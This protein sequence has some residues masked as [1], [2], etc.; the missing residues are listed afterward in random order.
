[1]CEMKE[2]LRHTCHIQG[3]LPLELFSSSLLST[4][5]GK[6][7][8]YAE[9]M[10]AISLINPLN[11][12][13]CVCFFLCFVNT[14]F[15]LNINFLFLLNIK[16]VTVELQHLCIFVLLAFLGCFHRLLSMG[17]MCKA[18]VNLKADFIELIK[19]W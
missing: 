14:I 6:L 7:S 3:I 1:M 10:D 11:R 17:A 12:A 16:F 9:H 8:S 2:V 15:L 13:V 19:L 5:D 4:K 18:N